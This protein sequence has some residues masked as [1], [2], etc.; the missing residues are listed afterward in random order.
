MSKYV[1]EGTDFLD[2]I[3]PETFALLDQKNGSFHDSFDIDLAAQVQ[4][5]MKAA[6]TKPGKKSHGARLADM[7]LAEVKTETE[8]DGDLF[9]QIKVG[10]EGQDMQLDLMEHNLDQKLAKADGKKFGDH[11]VIK[12]NAINS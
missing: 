2:A 1:T 7:A 12:V 9:L 4:Q 10:I 5:D 6:T 3:K 8:K 11:Q